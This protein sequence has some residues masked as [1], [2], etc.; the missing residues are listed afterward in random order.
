[1]CG[2][3]TTWRKE[4]MGGYIDTKR[5]ARCREMIRRHG[6]IGVTNR[7]AAHQ[8]NGT[9]YPEGYTQEGAGERERPGHTST[10]CYLRRTSLLSQRSTRIG[11]KNHK[12]F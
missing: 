8:S 11:H 1:M 2:A 12:K 9:W 6:P 4:S 7:D 3:E 5:L 10:L